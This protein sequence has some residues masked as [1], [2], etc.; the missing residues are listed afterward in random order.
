MVWFVRMRGD[1]FVMVESLSD[2]LFSHFTTFVS[3]A[4][5]ENECANGKW[6]R[7]GCF[8]VKSY[9]QLVHIVL[10]LSLSLSG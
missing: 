10:S 9:K 7:N 1:I 3:V 5:R 6:A 2:N 4:T 8:T